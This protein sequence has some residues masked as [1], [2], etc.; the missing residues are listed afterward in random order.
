MPVEGE[1]EEKRNLLHPLLAVRT[2]KGPAQQEG[3]KGKEDL[4]SPS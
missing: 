1:G 4:A 3:R 2:R